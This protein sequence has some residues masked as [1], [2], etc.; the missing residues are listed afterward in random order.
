MLLMLLIATIFVGVLAFVGVRKKIILNIFLTAYLCIFLA[1]F[2]LPENNLVRLT[3]GVSLSEWISLS[4]VFLVILGYIVVLKKIKTNNLAKYSS[5]SSKND[6]TDIEI[7]RYARHLVLKDIGGQGQQRLRNAK[8]LVV[9]AGGLGNPVSLY[10]AGAGI[11]TIGIIDNDI[12]SLSNLQ[13]QI[14]YR[15]HDVGKSKVFATQKNILEI[16]PHIEIKPY[17]RL[18]DSSNAQKLISEYDIIIDG[19]DNLKT[20]H[21]VNFACVKERKPLISGAISQWEGQISLFDPSKN[22]PCYSCIFPESDKDNLTR[23]C[24]DVGVLSSLPGVIGSLMAVEAIKEITG[25][26]D[27]LRG[28]LFLYDA[29]SCKTRKIEAERN[30]N[31]K[32]CSINEN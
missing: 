5:N 28:Q 9:G 17:N 7:E 15:E 18:L 1:I 10:L 24:A 3:L 25:V 13:R 21:L 32:V 2:F 4:F 16:N 20:R 19:S 30:K 22:Y 27:S 26:G 23:S 31:C 12:V 29:M 14:L 8:V 11:G 6:M